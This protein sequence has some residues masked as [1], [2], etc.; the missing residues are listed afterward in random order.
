LKAVALG[1]LTGL[2]GLA[3]GL[4]PLGFDLE[5]SVGLDLL[6]RLRGERQPP[7]DVLVVSIDKASADRLSLPEDPKQWPRALHARLI[8]TLTREGAAVVAFDVFF[9]EPRADEED[10][11]LAEALRKSRNV[12]LCE[13]LRGERVPVPG[14]KK[15]ALAGL[16][17]LSIKSPIPSL[18]G[19]A[20][21]LAPFPLP[22]VPV[23]V[24][25]FWTFTAG[26]GDKPTLPVL[27]FQVYALSVYGD[28][29]DLLEKAA[30]GQTKRLPGSKEEVMEQRGVEQLV[31][32]VREV[33]RGDPQF[34]ERMLE[35][36]D[37]LPALSGHAQKR[38]L[39]RSL[40]KLYQ[41][42]ESR[43]LNFYGPP[44]TVAT[45]PYH[46]ILHLGEPGEGEGTH[47][48]LKGKAVFIGS[49]E[50]VRIE[51]KDGFHTV[52]SQ[53]DGLDL[54]GVEIA[55]TAFANLLE[56]LPV[57]PLK[58]PAYFTVLF[59]WGLAVGFVCRLWPTL[60]AVLFTLGVCAAYLLATAHQFAVAGQWYPLVLP[61]FIQAPFALI[62]AVVWNYLD[63]QRDRKNIR[64]AFGYY[65]PPAVVDELSKNVSD[66]TTGSR[67]V[68][69]ICLSTDAEQYTALAE[70]MDPSELGQ[71]MN[72]YYHTVFHPVKQYGGFV[73]DVKGDSMLAIWAA[74]NPDPAIRKQACH[75]ALDIASGVSRFNQ[76]SGALRRLPT[77]IGLHS[78]FILLGSVGALDHYEYRPVGD[79][80]NTAS[81]IEGL[82]KYLGTRVLVSEEVIQGLEDFLTRELGRFLLV[83]KSRPITIY[84]LICHIEE[85]TEQHQAA[86]ACFAEALDTFRGQEWDKA[87]ERFSAIL[88][89]VGEDGPS[90]Y[91]AGLCL[92]YQS[93]PPEA[94]WEGVVRLEKK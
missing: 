64:K 63:A 67:L 22:K 76:S 11:L 28:F 55:A 30:P 1:L 38:R 91:Y 26:V 4:T 16:S 29:L 33:A 18:A 24:S 75:A 68:Y 57:R 12:V 87:M 47:L 50:I 77:R 72:R 20:A 39:L 94:S 84:E 3:V 8:E 32:A 44:R 66:V 81:R 48:D 31:K 42:E 7:P 59:L 80:V 46:Q 27:A 6:F 37:K 58:A 60:L 73:S 88:D 43:Y 41:S 45:V 17:I 85:S 9:G 71:L 54:S 90:R 62:G 53:E 19:S 69:G 83:G 74:A 14:K 13:I 10:R 65:L 25:Q 56:D 61:L 51:Q 92:Q 52:F 70:S 5:E 2:A 93:H 35:E 34:A 23:K 21:G 15:I 82:N 89:R 79:I 36:L 78:G 40:I 49:S 86:C